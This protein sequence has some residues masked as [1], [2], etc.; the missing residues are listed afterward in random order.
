MKYPIKS[1]ARR[2]FTLI[3]LS[4]VLVIIGLIVG[5]VLVGQDLIKA[6]EV[7]ATVSQVEKYNSAINTFRTKYNAVPGDL[8]GTLATNF[9]LL[10]TAR[11]DSGTSIH[12]NG[13]IEGCA[14]ILLGGCETV[15]FWQDLASASLIGDPI[16]GST[17]ATATITTA[18]LN[19]KF[20]AAKVDRGNRFI[21]YTNSGLNFYQLTGVTSVAAGVYALTSQLNPVEAF[22]MDNKMD[23]GA[24]LTGVV[25]ARLSTSVPGVISTVSD[26]CTN[27]S[28]AYDTSVNAATLACQ[29]SFRFN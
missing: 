6:A 14:T 10:P 18:Q 7:R 29:L 16:S 19:T 25:V 15:L 13:L 20:P 12:G 26:T 17:D 3:E 5:G 22:N 21:V 9:G 23:D 11:A 24:P 4:I 2:G 1:T 27:A 28:S 8:N